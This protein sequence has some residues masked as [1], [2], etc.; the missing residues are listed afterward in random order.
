MEKEISTSSY[1]FWQLNLLLLGFL[2]I[3]GFLVGAEAFKTLM[4]IVGIMA[5]F[6]S[7]TLGLTA[8]Y[9]TDEIARSMLLR[10][11]KKKFLLWLVPWKNAAY[12]FA[13][14]L[15]VFYPI[16]F[17]SEFNWLLKNPDYHTGHLLYC[18]WD[19]WQF[20]A[21]QISQWLLLLIPTIYLLFRNI[22]MVIIKAANGKSDH[23]AQNLSLWLLGYGLAALAIHSFMPEEFFAHF[24]GYLSISDSMCAEYV[25]P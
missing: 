18:A 7:A 21:V 24:S 22:G 12:V 14:I 10:L 23:I 17:G 9:S 2:V 6:L 1:V 5:T 13:W 11:S 3:I 15:V 20:W 8:R 25:H 4:F 16:N 19:S